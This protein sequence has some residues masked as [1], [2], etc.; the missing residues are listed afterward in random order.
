MTLNP[1]RG[2]SGWNW[3]RFWGIYCVAGPTCRTVAKIFESHGQLHS[4]VCNAKPLV[5]VRQSYCPSLRANTELSTCCF[6]ELAV[7]EFFGQNQGWS[8]EINAQRSIWYNCMERHRIQ[9]VLLWVKFWNHNFPSYL[10]YVV[11][12]SRCWTRTTLKTI[13]SFIKWAIKAADFIERF[14]N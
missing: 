5:Y 3:C 1:H 11:K 13:D 7:H 4:A 2:D 8:L 12:F 14:A 9:C 10:S 6:T